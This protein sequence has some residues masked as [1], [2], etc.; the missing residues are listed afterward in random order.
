MTPCTDAEALPLAGGVKWFTESQVDFDNVGAKTINANEVNM[1]RVTFD[2]PIASGTSNLLE[3]V[4]EALPNPS[5]T[6][7]RNYAAHRL[8]SPS[9]DVAWCPGQDM[10]SQTCEA[11]LSSN[12]SAGSPAAWW[13]IVN[14]TAMVEKSWMTSPVYNAGDTVRWR[15]AAY[16][17]PSFVPDALGEPITAT[18]SNDVVLNDILPSSLTYVPGSALSWN[19]TYTVSTPFPDPV[20]TPDT[21]SPGYST[22]EWDLGTMPWNTATHLSFDTDIS[23]F[24]PS[25][26]ITNYAEVHTQYES[27]QGPLPAFP[28]Q[29]PYLRR[30]S[31]QVTVTGLSQAIIAKTSTTPSIEAATT[32]SIT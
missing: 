22:L 10:A 30:M 7:L 24:T 18:G 13:R 20:I 17:N 31:S 29:D 1:I 28:I 2:G 32:R 4:W 11:P 12:I 15:V 5:G 6:Q 27:E 23:L 16:S 19:D 3:F 9:W 26:S 21:P 14:G 25:G 8:W